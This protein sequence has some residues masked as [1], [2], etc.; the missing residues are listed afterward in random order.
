MAYNWTTEWPGVYARH[1][2]DCQLRFG[3]DC[4]CRHVA[5]RASAKAPDDHSR[6]LSPE[7]GSAVEARDWLRDQRARLTA[8]IAVADEGP[9]VSTVIHDFLAAAERGDARERSGV[10][11][12]RPRISQLRA[13]LAYV[14]SEIGS[15]PLQAV[16]RRHV[17]GLIDNL[18]AAGL[19]SD[20]IVEVVSSFR[21]LFVYAIQRDLVDFN[22]IVQLRLPA[23]DG[24]RDHE[25][26]VTTAAYAV[27]QT[28]AASSNGH[29]PVPAAAAAG[30]QPFDDEPTYG[31]GMNV[32]P[33]PA[34]LMA[35]APVAQ[36]PVAEPL[37][38]Q[39]PVTQELPM[40]QAPVAEPW[41]PVL[42]APTAFTPPAA[43]GYPYDAA[44]MFAAP[45]TRMITPI[46]AETHYGTP[47]YGTESFPSQPTV[48]MNRR[49]GEDGVFMSE[50]MF[51]W[52]TRIVVIVFVLIALVLVAE[53]V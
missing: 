9:L 1:D 29:G 5:Y 18:H 44:P 12:T 3:G 37:T 50:Q 43:P 38:A 25:P 16:R 7:F 31:P 24:H 27:G 28:T 4:T 36:P 21:D 48:Q 35:E 51:W 10:E 49:D 23:E 52:I 39:S 30:D 8:A 26:L 11:F 19:P 6:L 46:G 40:E 53:S 17:Q 41:Q 34:Q 20:R 32:V 47:T 45:A 22:P 14:E 13:A 15:S 33:E 42:G 2:S